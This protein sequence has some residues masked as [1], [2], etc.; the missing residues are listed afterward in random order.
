M[1]EHVNVFCLKQYIKLD[2]I[3]FIR[4]KNENVWL[5]VAN[6]EQ[7]SIRCNS[8]DTNDIVLNGT[9]QITL[10]Q[11]CRLV[12]KDTLLI[13]F[14]SQS[15]NI[16]KKFFRPLIRP[17]HNLTKTQFNI[18]QQYNFSK[19]VNTD[20]LKDLVQQSKSHSAFE[21]E[22]GTLKD[23]DKLEQ[24]TNYYLGV[25]AVL[26]AIAIT[27]SISF[28]CFCQHAT[29]RPMMYHPEETIAGTPI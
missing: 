12:T 10:D 28:L 5:F 23:Q 24:G 1:I 26:T 25:L 13:T 11:R 29:K 9:G 21:E 20:N 3:I 15:G 16:S 17:I 2:N 18:I 14:K 4:F 27:L 22:I 6:N 7:A 8:G 19:Q